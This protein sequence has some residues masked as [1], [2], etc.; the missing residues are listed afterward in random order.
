MLPI[1]SVVRDAR[2]E[3]GKAFV[4]KRGESIEVC[5]GVERPRDR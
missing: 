1:T 2:G 4:K 3:I 5:Q